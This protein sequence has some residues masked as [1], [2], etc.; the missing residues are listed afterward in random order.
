[1]RNAIT[2]AGRLN[3]ISRREAVVGAVA[4]L[5]GLAF[6]PVRALADDEIIR[7]AEA[8]H[9]EPTFKA[10]RKRVYDVLTDEAQFQKVVMMSEAMRGGMAPNTASARI[11]REPGGEFLLF[12]GYV[13]GRQIE[14]V[15]G[16]RI[17]QA[18]RPASWKPGIFSIARFELVDDG[19]G[20]K[21]IFDHTGFP[22]GTAEHLASGWKGNYWDPLAKFLG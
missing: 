1:M 6:H 19:T 12:G 15:P 18:W 9:Q 13:S 16:E 17:V 20:T 22:N 7:T 4:A 11:S 8:I 21:I 14:L 2:P 10:S 3:R 5:G